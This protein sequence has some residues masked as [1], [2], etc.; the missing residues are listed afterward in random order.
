MAFGIW[1]LPI[2]KWQI[3]FSNFE[4]NFQRKCQ[5]DNVWVLFGS[6]LTPFKLTIHFKLNDQNRFLR[7]LAFFR[8]MDFVLPV[9]FQNNT[10]LRKISQREKTCVMRCFLI[11]FYAQHQPLQTFKIRKTTSF[12][13]SQN[14]IKIGLR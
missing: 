8:E 9:F 6:N 3:K 13:K 4:K 5:S 14:K 7:C 2:G 10:G 12:L 1:N 11:L